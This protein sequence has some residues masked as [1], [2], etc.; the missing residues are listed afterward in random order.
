MLIKQLSKNKN[1]VVLAF[2]ANLY[3]IMLCKLLGV[4]IIIRSNTSPSG[5]SKNIIKMFF[6]KHILKLA[7]E[8]VVNSEEFKKQ[9]KL[10]FSLKVFV[11][12]IL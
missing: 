5:W 9:L 6:Y 10:L 3:S 8:I 4:K 7:D 1:T 2:Q 12:I 11:F